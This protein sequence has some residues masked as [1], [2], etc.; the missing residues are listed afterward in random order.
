[1]SLGKYVELVVKTRLRLSGGISP[2]AV[3][4]LKTL[5]TPAALLLMTA[6][7][8]LCADKTAIP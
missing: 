6:C 8:G 4:T 7:P 5:E 2:P 3:S 1:L